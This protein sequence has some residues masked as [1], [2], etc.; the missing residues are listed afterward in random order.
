[1]ILTVLG[2]IDLNGQVKAYIRADCVHVRS[3]TG[4]SIHEL[5]GAARAEGTS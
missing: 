5:L 1:M 3:I 4:S 2:T